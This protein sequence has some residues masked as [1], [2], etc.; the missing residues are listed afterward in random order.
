MT[1]NLPESAKSTNHTHLCDLMIWPKRLSALKDGSVEKT[2]PNFFWEKH[3]LRLRISKVACV[4][5]LLVSLLLW[6]LL[7]IGIRDPTIVY[8][9][10]PGEGGDQHPNLTAPIFVLLYCC[11]FSALRRTKCGTG[12]PCG[13]TPRWSR[14][15]MCLSFRPLSTTRWKGFLCK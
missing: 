11:C 1:D 7:V 3:C 10:L 6:G 2:F 15:T 14:P 4:A 8:V 5:V 9:V 13:T 12:R